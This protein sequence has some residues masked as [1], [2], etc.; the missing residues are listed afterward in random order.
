M[1]GGTDLSLRLPSSDAVGWVALSGR[2]KAP[3][4][5]AA[6]GV[7]GRGAFVLEV[8]LPLPQAGFLLEHAAL[9]GWPRAFSVAHD[10]AAGLVITHLQGRSLCR[11]I[12][13]GPLPEG[14]GIGRL[15]FSFD[16]PRRFW[17][18]RFERAGDP[19]G[20]VHAAGSATL[21]LNL[22]DLGA[23]CAA[24]PGTR[25]HPSVLWFGATEQMTAATPGAWFGLRT[26]VETPTGPV[27]A[28]MLRPGDPVLTADRGILPVRA[29]RPVSV[30]SA[31]STAPVLLRAPYFA[32]STDLQVGPEVHL[33]YEGLAA[34]YLFGEDAV[35]VRA[36]DLCD[37]M[38]AAPDHRRAEARGVEIDLGTE[39]LLLSDGCTLMAPSALRA[40]WVSALRRLDPMEARALRAMRRATGRNIAA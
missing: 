24:A 2:A 17:T 26:P 15:T 6:Q 39:A 34:Q 9:D 29:L 37:G 3:E 25:R 13:A 11:H 30:P 14:E 5:D 27:A 38:R 23:L 28:A 18:M 19:E 33:F 4:A 36:G 10:L 35:L 22:G 40:G 21:P 16:A 31:G 20:A 1:P 8:L 32:R 12:L 7:L